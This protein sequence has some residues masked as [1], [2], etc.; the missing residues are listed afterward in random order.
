MNLIRE[1]LSMNRPSA[2]MMACLL[3]LKRQLEAA[4]H[5]QAGPLV[6]DF[7]TLHGRSKQTVWRWLNVFAEY[8]PDR[9]PR[10]DA[11]KTKC[12]E[13]TLEFIAASKAVGVRANGKA[14]KPTAVAMNIAD[15]NGLVVNVGAGQI[16]RIL[17]RRKLDVKSQANARNHGRLRAECPNAVHE[18]DP[19]LCLIY[20]MGKRQL[21]MTEAEFNKNKPAAMERVKLKVWRYTRY[22]H[23][24][25]SI[26]V[27]YYEAAGENQA[28]LFDFLLYTWSE[29]AQRL[30]H[31]VPK[32]LLWD[33]GSANTSSGIVKLLDALG[34]AHET[35]ATHHA[36]V[37]GGVEKAN[38]IVEMHFESRLREQPVAS[39]DEL[40]AAA[41]R[42]VRDYN[43]NAIKHVDSRVRRHDGQA[44]VRDDLWQLILRYPGALVKMPDRK[45]CAWYLTGKDA[46]RQVK[47]GL[48][49]FVHPEIG[50][51]RVY[52][53]SQWAAF[54]S[55]RDKVQVWP[56]LLAEGRVRV[57]IDRLGQEPLLVEV[58]PERDFTEFGNL[59]SAALIGE[60][61]RRAKMTI[62]ERAAQDIADT[63]YGVR[64]L[65]EAEAKLRQNVRPFQQ[66]N[67]GKGMVAHSH[68]GQG[69]LPERLLPKAQELALR[70]AEAEQ[71]RLNWVQMATWLRGRL[72]DDYRPD[73][74]ADLQKRFPD[75][76]TE[77][78]L[79]EV[80][81]DIRAGR[82]A[83]GRAK[84]QAV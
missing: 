9:K 80:L 40:N 41:E 59:A 78:D 56:M 74:L 15:A 12:P 31:G 83:A 37:K 47:D 19:S 39:V 76:A 7:A 53:L 49:S 30:S 25:A 2:E 20:Y 82:T 32:R 61:H 24:S 72:Q 21:M 23:A 73:M 71:K 28:S 70:V 4:A 67:D 26:D 66:F 68:L 52:N 17:R 42:W 65:D 48:I 75:G 46:T 18:I 34:V 51:S 44:H 54:Y 81:V 69:E 5:G 84:L 38:H 29:Q 8:R 14:T 10:R 43:A 27:R 55:Q 3:E 63:A 13:A 64:D 22:D 45:V 33:K 1:W 16:N 57:A 58:E 36:W 11:G 60:E 50:K 77:P 79:E 6:N 62:A 35:H